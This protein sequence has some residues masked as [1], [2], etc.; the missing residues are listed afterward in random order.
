M[1]VTTTRR[2][3]RRNAVFY[4][5][6]DRPLRRIRQRAV[7]A[8][9]L[10]PGDTAI[11]VGDLLS[12]PD[13]PGLICQI[14]EDHLR[15]GLEALRMQPGLSLE[16]RADLDQIRLTDSTRDYQWMERYYASR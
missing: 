14:P 16:S 4:N 15:A 9:Q 13:S 6:V 12:A 3:Y 11:S 8:L 2:Q 10:R 1:D 5:L 7:A